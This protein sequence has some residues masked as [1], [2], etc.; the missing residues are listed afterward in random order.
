MT[1]PLVQKDLVDDS[2]VTVSRLLTDARCA[3]VIFPFL[4]RRAP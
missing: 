2:S 3:A 1:G 4:L